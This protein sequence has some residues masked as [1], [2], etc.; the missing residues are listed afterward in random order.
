MENNAD[1]F[2]QMFE[3][4]SDKANYPI[5]IS[6]AIGKDK[7]GITSALVLSAIGVDREQI[8]SDFLLS[9]QLID[10]DFLVPNSEIYFSDV[11]VQE[12]MTSMFSAHHEVI[13]YILDRVAKQYGSMDKFLE[14]EL[15]LTSHKKA[16]L[17]E[18]ML[19]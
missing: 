2:K 5:V 16:K 17:R 6:C 7:T 19:Y 1:Y 10:Y 13:T 8:I 18:I 4:L 12:T 11:D 9:N 14:N 3:I 15:K